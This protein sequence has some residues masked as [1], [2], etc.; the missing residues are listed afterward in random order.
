MKHGCTG[1]LKHLAQAPQNKGVLGAA[2]TIEALAASGIWRR[3]SDIAEIV[4]I[5]AIG[6]AKHLS[7]LNGNGFSETPR[8]DGIADPG[9]HLATNALRLTTPIPNDPEGD[10]PLD[11][12]LDLAQRSD[13]LTVQSEGT[14]VLVNVIKGL[15]ALQQAGLN[16]LQ[17]AVP[18]G[19]KKSVA[20]QEDPPVDEEKRKEAI[21][22]LLTLDTTEA[23]AEMLARSGRYPILLNEAIVALTLLSTQ[24]PACEYHP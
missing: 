8:K 23:L 11:L 10:S 12:I 18:D 22:R 16:G 5:N 3:E 13:E 1:L 20:S 19:A 17:S 24:P 2:G 4:Q 9:T 6:V 21:A 7:Y 15:F 14:R